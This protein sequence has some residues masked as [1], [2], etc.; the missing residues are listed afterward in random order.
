[1]DRNY[2]PLI[3][4]VRPNFCPTRSLGIRD[5]RPSRLEQLSGSLA[6]CVAESRKRRT[7]ATKFLGSRSCSFFNNRATL[8]KL[9]IDLPFARHFIKAV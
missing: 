1:V 9:Y 3:T 5:A 8:A 4:C 6:V 2:L 7:D